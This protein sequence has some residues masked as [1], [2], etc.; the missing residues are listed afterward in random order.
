MANT[1]DVTLA[2]LNTTDISAETV[3]IGGKDIAQYISERATGTKVYVEPMTNEGTMIAK[4]SCDTEVK[5]IYAP[6]AEQEY[7][8]LEVHPTDTEISAG[9]IDEV[10]GLEY[11]VA[12]PAQ[13]TCKFT[14]R[15]DGP[16][17]YDGFRI[18]W[19]DGTSSTLEDAEKRS[20]DKATFAHTYSASGRYIVKFYGQIYGF[21]NEKISDYNLISRIWDGDLP[22]AHGCYCWKQIC[23][24]AIRLQKVYIPK[25]F[26]WPSEN[27]GLYQSFRNAQNLI[28]FENYAPTPFCHSM[29]EMFKGCL[30]MTTC[31]MEYERFGIWKSVDGRYSDMFNGCSSLTTPV[32]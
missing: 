8:A 32:N 22:I 31:K 1:N 24:G 28:S 20:G 9:T 11:K 12:V 21:I 2:T 7:T 14:V 13:M 16:K 23:D 3:K 15:S 17:A 26:K 29:Q 5:E 30:N 25:S 4:I 27:L 19:G 10:T 6:A 18:D